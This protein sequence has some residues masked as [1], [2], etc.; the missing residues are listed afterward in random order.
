VGIVVCLRRGRGWLVTA[1]LLPLLTYYAG[2]IAVI[3]YVYDRFLIGWLPIM[4]ALGGIGLAAL[5]D[6]RRGT[7]VGKVLAVGLVLVGVTNAVAT[8][9]VFTRD[10]RH[11]AWAW[12]RAHVPCGSSVG[13]TFNGRY[14]PPLDCLDMWELT[15]GA[16]DG[17]IRWPQ[18]LVLN[19]AYLQR[20][21][22][23]PS[24]A[25]F[26]AALISGAAGYERLWRAESAP[27][28]WAPL[29]WE[30]RFWNG[31][32]DVE[33]TA[34]K[35]LHAIEVWECVT[36]TGCDRPVAIKGGTTSQ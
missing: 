15:P 26:H 30:P 3:L 20:F 10:P 9:I 31:R 36:R 21:R 33:T 34:D 14:V 23:S 18:Y 28:R 5:L 13:V 27:P 32:E 19:E 17:M 8:T 16:I 7:V 29:Y 22:D 35:P 24:G 12:V 1:L 11:D 6:V 25:A 2:F 4:S